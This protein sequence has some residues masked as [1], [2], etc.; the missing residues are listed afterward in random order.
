MTKG[1]STAAA[2]EEVQANVVAAG[3]GSGDAA[4]GA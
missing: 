2:D 1:A 4:G 3:Y